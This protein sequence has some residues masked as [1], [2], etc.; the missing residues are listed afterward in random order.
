MTKKSLVRDSCVLSDRKQIA[1]RNHDGTSTA[2]PTGFSC[3]WY[4]GWGSQRSRVC[5]CQKIFPFLY[6]NDDKQFTQKYKLKRMKKKKLSSYSTAL[7]TFFTIYTPATHS[8]RTVT[9]HSSAS[10]PPALLFPY[11]TYIPFKYTK[12]TGS[13]LYTNHS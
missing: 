6:N 1:R 4:T 9:Q 12:K 5:Q 11:K 3:R 10:P 8:W 7:S 2:K 13:T